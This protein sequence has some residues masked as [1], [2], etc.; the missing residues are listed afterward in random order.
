MP[1]F[2]A[3]QNG[4]SKIDHCAEHNLHR[5]G[6][7]ILGLRQTLL[8]VSQKRAVLAVRPV[9]LPYI[10]SDAKH[11]TTHKSDDEVRD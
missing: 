11:D 3:D 9:T 10:K 4:T 5:Q 7:L 6:L 8:E 2:E 1:T